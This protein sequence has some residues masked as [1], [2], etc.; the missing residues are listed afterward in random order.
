[1]VPVAGVAVSAL[2]DIGTDYVFLKIE[3][4]QEREGYKEELISEIE[5]ERAAKLAAIQTLSISNSVE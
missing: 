3:E 2:F 5:D 4:S 1:L